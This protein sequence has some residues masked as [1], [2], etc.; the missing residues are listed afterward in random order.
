MITLDEDTTLRDYLDVSSGKGIR[1]V[2]RGNEDHASTVMRRHDRIAK[3]ADQNMEWRDAVLNMRDLWYE[4][5]P[6]TRRADA[7]FVARSLG[8]DLVQTVTWWLHRFSNTSSRKC[9]LAV[10]ELP[11][12]VMIHTAAPTEPVKREVAM[13]GI[14]MG[15]VVEVHHTDKMRKYAPRSTTP[16][17]LQII[18]Q[19]INGIEVDSSKRRKPLRSPGNDSPA[20]RAHRRNPELV[21]R[22][23]LR[24]AVQ[25]RDIYLMRDEDEVHREVFDQIVEKLSPKVRA[26]LIEVVGKEQP[27]EAFEAEHK[28][29]ARSAKALL[30]HALDSLRHVSAKEA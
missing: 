14:V 12:A 20:V 21:S 13:F 9:S 18:A 24:L 26:L 27:L 5:S 8:L 23:D 2:A 16:D 10:A 4:T 30:S 1:E 19:Q 17:A 25:F 15:W 11:K 6:Y 28:Y 22:N 29:P 7:D 3:L